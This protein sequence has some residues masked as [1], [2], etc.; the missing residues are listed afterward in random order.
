MLNLETDVPQ[1]NVGTPS[2]PFGVHRDD[3]TPGDETGTPLLKK[4][5]NDLYY[6]FYAVI[7]KAGE[8]LNNQE[9]NV[10]TSNFFNALVT[11]MNQHVSADFL[12]PTPQNTPDNTIKLARGVVS[13]PNDPIS[14]PII[15]AADAAS[16]LPFP[17]VTADSRIDRLVYDKTGA[18]IQK[19]GTQEAFPTP[20]ALLAGEAPICRTLITTIGTPVLDNLQDLITDER[21]INTLPKLDIATTPGKVVLSGRVNANGTINKT[22]AFVPGASFSVAKPGSGTYDITLAGLG[23]FSNVVILPIKNINS[24]GSRASFMEGITDKTLDTGFG[25]PTGFRAHIT[26]L[27]HDTCGGCPFMDSSSIDE[28]WSFIVIGLD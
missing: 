8:T 15:I 12:N 23:I 21:V 4:T 2:Q 18:I 17:G 25:T 9:E 27:F 6:A 16:G 13:D 19:L 1:T 26:D 10:N 14:E 3:I 11:L 22:T 20:P 24:G 7:Q 5:Q 28:V